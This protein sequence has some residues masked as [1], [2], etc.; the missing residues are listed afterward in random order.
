MKQARPFN[1][2]YQKMQYSPFNITNQKVQDSPFKVTCQKVQYVVQYI[3]GKPHTL[4]LKFYNFITL[5]IFSFVT[6]WF[7]WTS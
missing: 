5:P 7:H 6:P 2:A 1:V 3:L 4:L